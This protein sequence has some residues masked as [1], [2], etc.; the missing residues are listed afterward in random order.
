MRR[1]A[2]I[3]AAAI[4]LGAPMGT[5][6]RQQDPAKAQSVLA[7]S[8][9][10]IGGKK[11]D[12]LRS[13]GLE[14]TVQRNMGNIQL[15]SDV[16]LLLD[17]PDKYVR[18][19]TTS[20]PIGGGSTTG[21]NGEKPL[22]KFNTGGGGMGGMVIRMGG[23]GGRVTTTPGQ[24]LSPEEQQKVDRAMVRAARVDLS[25]LMLGWFAM[26]HPQVPAEY[27]YAGEAESP[28]GKAYVIDAMDA[29]GFAA[30]LFID[31]QTH[32][33]LMVTYRAPQ[34]R[35]VTAGGP[36]GAAG[37]GPQMGTTG[38]A[39]PA[40]PPTPPT[41][42]ERRKMREEADRQLQE[43]Q[44][45][46]PAMADYTLYFEDWQDGDGIKFPRKIRRAMAGTTS[47]EWTVTKVKV[48]P[49]IDPKKFAV[50]G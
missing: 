13:L 34:P 50:E 4:V 49:T 46:P 33:P 38:G 19:E 31:E 29:D 5:T 6:A 24:K 35:I 9:A 36:G 15:S 23:P 47:E 1:H 39:R 43:L 12:S 30:R 8:R 28:D 14:A 11:L 17:L 41:E 10:A 45:Q 48:N 42:E 37:G 44:K 25:R 18:S 3:I 21:F 22:Q 7:E 26:T 32:L 2:R 27:S 16:E 20:G 40:A